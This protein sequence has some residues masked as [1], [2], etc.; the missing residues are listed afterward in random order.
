MPGRMLSACQPGPASVT[1]VRSGGHSLRGRVCNR[2]EGA[3]FWI[4]ITRPLGL[5]ALAR[6]LL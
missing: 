6:P 1:R 4:G 5:S 2:L 3:V